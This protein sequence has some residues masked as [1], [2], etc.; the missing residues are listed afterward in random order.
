MKI[1]ALGHAGFLFDDGTRLIIDPFLTGNPTAP[2]QPS[3]LTRMDVV[4]VTHSHA[5]HLGDAYDIVKKTGATLVSVHDL[6]VSGEVAGEG[7]NFGGTMN[8]RGLPITMVKA[9]H[10]VGLGDAAG[11]IW[12]QGGKVIYHMGDTS[13]FSDMKFLG[14]VYKPDILFVPIGDRYTMNPKDAVLATSWINPKMVIPMHYKTF[15]F[16]VQDPSVFKQLCESTCKAK[17]KI[18]EAGQS[19]EI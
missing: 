4:L 10:S 15:P 14:E 18:L 16:L 19:L 9:E 13:L 17:V 3:Y 1:T 2:F 11:F 12:S 6:A 5:D 8:V 7:M